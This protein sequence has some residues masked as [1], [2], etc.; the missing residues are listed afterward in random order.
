MKKKLYRNTNNALLGGVLA[1]LADY[2][3][4][5]VVFWR[6]GFLF[7]LILTG[8][9]PC[10]LMYLAAWIIVPEIPDYTQDGTRI[11]DQ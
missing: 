1:G 6:L 9:M 8:L 7:L 5:D 10:L 4:N 11:Y 3:E 2:Y